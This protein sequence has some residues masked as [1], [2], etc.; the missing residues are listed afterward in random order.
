MNKGLQRKE[1]RVKNAFS[2]LHHCSNLL[3]AAFLLTVTVNVSTALAEEPLP[4]TPDQQQ[5]LGIVL[6]S[7]KQVTVSSSQSYPADVIIPNA[8][9]YSVHSPQSGIVARLAKAVGDKVTRGE[10]VAVI[11][12][13]DLITVQRDYVQA[14]GRVKQLEVE[15]RRLKQLKDEGIVAERRFQDVNSRLR[16]ARNDY[17]ALEQQLILIGVS[18]EELKQFRITGEY[19]SELELKSEVDGVVMEQTVTTG[20]RIS[21]MDN[22]YVVADLST[23]WLEVHVPL[24]VVE[25]INIGDDAKVAD[26]EVTGQVT[27]IGRQ[28]HQ[29][30]QGVMVRVLVDDNT[31]LLTPGEF[32]QVNFLTSTSAMKQRY[33]IPQSALVRL[34]GKEHVFIITP[35]GFLP[36]TVVVHSEKGG[37]SIIEIPGERPE[38]IVIQGLA[39]LKAAWINR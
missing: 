26:R 4:L 35:S 29:I 22:L 7:L 8:N 1:A 39:A 38:T 20:Q 16:L 13:S 36:V 31:G 2:A 18:E 15:W 23:L 9:R 10:L 21:G 25:N 3:I 17:Q 33:S 37:N 28:V 14:Y 6:A 34:E 19:D 30:D 12:S 11:K 32:V 24:G 5:N 27:A